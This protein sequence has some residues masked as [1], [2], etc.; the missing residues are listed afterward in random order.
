[1]S[2]C[3]LMIFLVG[4]LGTFSCLMQFDLTFA[5]EPVSANSSPLT[6]KAL[7][8]KVSKDTYYKTDGPVSGPRAPRL[9]EESYPEEFGES[10]VVVWMVAQQHVY[11]SGFVVGG[12]FLV[13]VLEVIGLMGWGS[14]H[15]QSYDRFATEIFRFIVLALGIAGSL[16]GIFLV[17]LLVLYPDLTTY[18]TTVFRPVFLGYGALVIGFTLL[19]YGL[20]YSW[21]KMQRGLLK[22]LHA[23]LGVLVNVLGIVLTMLG[24]AWSSF[25]LAPAGV[26][27]HGAFLGNTWHVLHTALWN[28]LNVHR[29]ASHILLGAAVVMA[30]G[31]YR[32]MTAVTF[33]ERQ[34]YDWLSCVAFVC[35]VLALLTMPIGGYWLMREIYAYK[36]QMGITLLGGLLAW[37]GVVLVMTMGLLFFSINYYLWQRIDATGGSPYYGRYAKYVYAILS[38]CMMVSITPHTIV[39]TPLEL[40][41]MGGQQHPVLGNYG[42]ESAKSTAAWLMSIVTLWSWVL[43]QRCGA[44][45]Y[46]FGKTKRDWFLVAAFMMG[47]ANIIAI[48]SYGY[49]LPANVRIGL[50]LSMLGTVLSLCLLVVLFRPR[51]SVTTH[52]SSLWG[53]MSSRGYRALILLAFTVSWL[54][55]LGGYRRSSVRSYWHISDVMLDQ[56]SWA[57]THNIGFAA[58]IISLNALLFWFGIGFIFWM[59]RGKFNFS[60]TCY[61]G[62]LPKTS[63]LISKHED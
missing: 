59:A 49:F 28:P 4:Y 33:E 25:M 56:S 38:L 44:S 14:G 63:S 26:S 13:T 37:L 3:L 21:E 46:V 22:W 34:H 55:G 43:W 27:E 62:L 6:S 45:D 51:A 8:S 16:G 36:Q 5:L 47:A 40:Q 9:T 20:Y 41:Q 29:I 2:K 12:L 23:S 32:A 60:S 7:K 54:M 50:Q 52:S 42:V 31:A 39:M 10:R 24:N 1:M 57:F 53:A 58:N 61:G 18:L 30:Y 15:P 17:S 35:G 19:A 11:W 48:G